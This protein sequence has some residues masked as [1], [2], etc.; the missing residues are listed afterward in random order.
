MREVSHGALLSSL[1]LTSTVSLSRY[2]LSGVPLA[3]SKDKTYDLLFPT[4]SPDPGTHT[5]ITKSSF[6]LTGSESPK[7]AYNPGIV[8]PCPHCSGPR[9]FECQLMPNM[10]NTLRRH[11][12]AKPKKQS[13]EERRAE[14]ARSLARDQ[15]AAERLEMEWGTCLVFCCLPNCATREGSEARECWRE[16][17][18]HVQWEE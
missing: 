9:A 4:A 11:S 17:L 8:A 10:L 2:D 12:R 5:V 13:D 16:E 1:S 3:Y 18:V 7:R 6:S 14:L 15:T